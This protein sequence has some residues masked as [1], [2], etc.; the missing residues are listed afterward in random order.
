M[1]EWGCKPG[2]VRLTEQTQCESSGCVPFHGRP[3]R[4][5][6]SHVNSLRRGTNALRQI[7]AQDPSASKKLERQVMLVP[8]CGN[9][10]RL[11]L[12]TTCGHIFL[13]STSFPPSS[14]TFSRPSC[15]WNAPLFLAYLS[16]L[17]SLLC[18]LPSCPTFVSSIFFL[19]LFV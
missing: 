16:F 3:P 19:P 14:L 2:R 4:V 9:G 7:A 18:F 13:T 11:L 5:R 15:F 6:R 10:W 17:Q 1:P 12:L 8:Q